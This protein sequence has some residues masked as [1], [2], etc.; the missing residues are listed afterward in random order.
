MKDSD[1]TIESLLAG[2]RNAEPPPGMHHRILDAMVARRATTRQFTPAITL[3]RRHG[4]G[5]C[6]RNHD[7]GSTSSAHTTKSEKLYDN[8][9]APRTK[10]PRT[11]AGITPRESQRVYVQSIATA[12]P[13]PRLPCSTIAFD[14]AGEAATTSRPSQRRAGY[15]FAQPRCAGAAISKG[16]PAVS[17]ILRDG[18][19]PDEER[20]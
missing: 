2:L 3:G 16:Y 14:R 12:N 11:V 15:D 1:R 10:P 6:A 17:A 9:D 19:Q 20:K 7:L 18:F 13:D 8:V 5:L 4:V